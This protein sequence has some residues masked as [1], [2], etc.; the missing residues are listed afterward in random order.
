MSLIPSGNTPTSRRSAHKNTLLIFT[1]TPSAGCT[2]L[3]SKTKQK[4]QNLYVS[5]WKCIVKRPP[6]LISFYRWHGCDKLTVR[7]L[8]VYNTHSARTMCSNQ[9]SWWK[10]GKI[11]DL[12][13]TWFRF[14]QW[15]WGGKGYLY[16]IKFELV[17]WFK[18]H[19]LQNIRKYLIMQLIII[20]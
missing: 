18:I 13:R 17:F 14:T 6:I 2:C 15:K 20:W 9:H 7:L 10:S 19:L 1:A 16:V 11:I 8:K 12:Q 3:F 5:F 4:T